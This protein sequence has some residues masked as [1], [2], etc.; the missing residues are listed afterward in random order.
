LPVSKPWKRWRQRRRVA[1]IIVRLMGGLGNQMFQY[2]CGRALALR[3]GHKLVLDPSDI[4]GLSSPGAPRRYSLQDFQLS[5]RV[6][7]TAALP[8]LLD[9]VR[10]RLGLRM[11]AVPQ[12]VQ[13]PHIPHAP[14]LFPA[15]FAKVMLRGYW[16]SEK[17]FLD[18]AAVIRRDFTLPPARLAQL[19]PPLR[20]QVEATASVSLHIRRGDY[21]QDP[22]V[23]RVL[24]VC[25]LDYYQRAVACLASRVPAP[26]F[27]VFSDD[28]AWVRANL[29]LDYPLHLVSDG[30]RRPSEE[31][32]LMA[33]CRHHIT[34]N[35]SFSWWGA[36]LNPRP[37]KLVCAPRIWFRDPTLD[38][39]DLVPDTWLRC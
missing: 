3:T 27:F 30:Q 16:Q 20:R 6:S 12:L 7:A 38:A 22:G 29:R 10:R 37:D 18:H 14:A 28:P 8:G 21:A 31:L 11:R 17:Y 9:Q 2:A 19:D 15:H 39:R 24:G 4:V 33:H 26:E 13:E 5:V 35:S 1:M 32:T 36:W 25:P 34:A 23:S